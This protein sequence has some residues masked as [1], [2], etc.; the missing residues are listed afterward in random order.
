MNKTLQLLWP[1]YRTNINRFKFRQNSNALARSIIISLLTIIASIGFYFG[2]T[3]LINELD[4]LKNQVYLSVDK[5]LSIFLLF[6]FV[7]LIISNIAIALGKFYQSNDLELL[8]ASPT[9]FLSIFTSKF[10]LTC[11]AASWMPFIFILP[12]TIAFLNSNNQVNIVNILSIALMLIPY[13]IWPT[14]I[15]I[16]FSTIFLLL[17]IKN[18]SKVIIFIALSGIAYLAWQLLATINSPTT[19]LVSTN[20]ILKALSIVTLGDIKWLP[21]NWVSQSFAKLLNGQSF[22]HTDEFI[23]LCSSSL[24]LL[25]FS[26]LFILVFFDLALSKDKS[27]GPATTKTTMF[28]AILAF[29]IPNQQI[30]ALALKEYAQMLRE[31]TQLIQVLL[32]IIMSSVYLYHLET[33]A[34]ASHFSIKFELAWTAF[35]SITTL[36]VGCFFILAFTTRVVFPS[37]SLEGRTFWYLMSKPLTIDKF[38]MSKFYLWFIPIAI[39]SALFFILGAKSIHID[40]TMLPLIAIFAIL[41]AYSASGVAIGLGAKFANFDW[42]Y[43]GQLIASF[44]SILYMLVTTLILAIG[45]IPLTKVIQLFYKPNFFIEQSLIVQ[46]LIVILSALAMWLPHIIAVRIAL[47]LGVDELR[48]NI[49]N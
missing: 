23:L 42:E 30:R 47:K 43:S 18:Y 40:S 34:F 15:A 6:L 38:L 49:L 14:A 35:L 1:Y 44:G 9:N 29:I 25:T 41:S 21:A 36:A 13:F 24:A 12:V 19:N 48:N 27:S 16:I 3:E 31:A 26:F 17:G 11:Y 5:L 28:R 37:V 10:T 32:L 39:F 22:I 2:A 7:T 46:I 20:G 8:L 4:V 45:C 33:L